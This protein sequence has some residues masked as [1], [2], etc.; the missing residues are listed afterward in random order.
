MISYMVVSTWRTLRSSVSLLFSDIKDFH[1]S[2]EVDLKD[3][4]LTLTNIPKFPDPKLFTLPCKLQDA[5][6]EEAVRL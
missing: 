2:L 1:T 5:D 6:G 4:P 3:D